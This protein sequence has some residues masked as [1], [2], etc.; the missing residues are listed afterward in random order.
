MPNKTD[1]ALALCLQKG[2]IDKQQLQ[3]LKMDVVM[4]YFTQAQAAMKIRMELA[5][6]NPAFDEDVKQK[7]LKGR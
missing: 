2:E 3:K 1:D 4:T 7:I 5:K 6:M